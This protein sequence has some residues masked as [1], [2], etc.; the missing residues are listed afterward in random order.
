M[1]EMHVPPPDLV[2]FSAFLEKLVS[3]LVAE[4]VERA[5]AHHLLL[6]HGSDHMLSHPPAAVPW[7]GQELDDQTCVQLLEILWANQVTVEEAANYLGLPPQL[8][9]RSLAQYS[10]RYDYWCER[11]PEI[12]R[13]RAS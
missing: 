6:Y 9:Q 8:V 3:E 12:L 10:A 5:M 13:R 4:G 11:I 1:D 2:V 7:A